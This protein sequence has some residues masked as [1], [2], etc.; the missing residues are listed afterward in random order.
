MWSLVQRDGSVH[1]LL[2]TLEPLVN[3][4]HTFYCHLVIKCNNHRSVVPHTGTTQ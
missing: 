2:Y 4:K 3:I 1:L